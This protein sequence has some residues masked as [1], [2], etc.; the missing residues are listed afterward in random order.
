MSRVMGDW[1]ILKAV[2][3]EAQVVIGTIKPSKGIQWIK[4]FC[5]IS[6]ACSL[7]AAGVKTWKDGILLSKHVRPFATNTPTCMGDEAQSCASLML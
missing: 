1:L 7:S 4:L 5:S 6:C 2:L 3:T